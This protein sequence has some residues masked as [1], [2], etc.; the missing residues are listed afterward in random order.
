M[1]KLGK[2]YILGDS[3][4]TFEGYMPEGYGS[5]YNKEDTN[6]ANITDVSQ[7]WW[8]M[9]LS[10][11]DSELVLNSSWS[12]TTICN[13][14][15]DGADCRNSSFVSRFKKKI[16]EGFFTENKID[17]FFIFGGTNDN[18]A[19]SPVG[20]FKY[21]DWTEQDLY[22]FLP[23]LCCFLNDV[24]STLT[25]TRIVYIINSELKDEITNGIKTAC[26]HYG[27]ETIELENISKD[28]GHP[29]DKGMVDIKNA[30]LDYFK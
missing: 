17:T 16:K 9:L 2:I 29:T 24:K 22:S 21:S 19:N 26:K 7:T 5:W 23:A 6:K 27:V 1:I 11:T 15:Y 8:K 30:I 13:T 10:E 25:D 4:S 20:E 12:G 3:Y 28:Y 18:W 14:G